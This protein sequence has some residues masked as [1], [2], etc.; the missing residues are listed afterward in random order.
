[1]QMP[2]GFRYIGEAIALKI[3]TWRTSRNDSREQRRREQHKQHWQAGQV[4]GGAVDQLGFMTQAEAVARVR[5]L[6]G[7][8]DPIVFIDFDRGF[9]AFGK[10][11]D[12]SE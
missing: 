5:L 8:D 4:A 10:H 1:M 3:L 6:K 12:A 9:I 11:P 2:I 7:D